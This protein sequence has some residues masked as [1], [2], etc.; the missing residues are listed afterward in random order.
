MADQNVRG[1]FVWHELMTPDTAGAHT[2]YAKV[3]GWKSQA[4]EQDASY[5]MFV[6]PKGPLGGSVAQP[7]GMPR[8]LHYIGTPDIDATVQQARK[9]GA[10]VTK[11]ITSIPDMGKY[12][13]LTDPQGGEFAVYW[14][15]TEAPPESPP[16]RGEFSWHELA[17]TDAAAAFEFYSAL[18]G[19]ETMEEMQSPMG[20]Y[21]IYGSNGVQRG[22]MYTKPAEMPGPSFWLGYVR[23]PDAHQAVKTAKGARGTLLHGPMQPPGGDWVATLTDPYGTM[24]AVHSLAADSK[25]AKA[26]PAAKKPAAKPAAEKAAAK[27]PAA[28]KAAAKPAAKKAAKPAAKKKAGAKAAKKA[29]KKPAKKAAKKQRPAAKAAKRPARKTAAKAARKSAGRKSAA[30]ARPAA[31]KKA[32]KKPRKAK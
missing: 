2:F 17:T 4:W 30:K 7:Q 3:L 28:T 5:T 32:A 19:W 26:K 22:G 18:F 23:V 29:A 24:F 15:A 25:A 14:S 6:G 9:L 21:I 10:T 20:V 13:T 8:W 1:R 16:E 31:G 11:E 12:A 27:A